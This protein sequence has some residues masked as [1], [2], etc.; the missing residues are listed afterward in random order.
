MDRYFQSSAITVSLKAITD[1]S[2]D[3]DYLDLD[4]F[5]LESH[6]EISLVRYVANAQNECTRC[7]ASEAKVSGAGVMTEVDR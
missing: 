2:L 6:R 1:G 7:G 4:Y 3:L 5:C